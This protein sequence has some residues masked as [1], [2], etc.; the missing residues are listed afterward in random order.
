VLSNLPATVL[1]ELPI[2]KNSIGMSFKLLPAGEFIMG[3]PA[4]VEGRDS[5]ETHETQHKVTLTKAFYLGIHAV[6]RGQFSAFVNETNY[7]TEAEKDGKGGQGVDSAAKWGSS[8]KPENSWRTFGMAQTD[9]HPVVNVTWNDAIAFCDWLS[10]KEGKRY[11]L[12]TEAEWEYGCRAGI[13]DWSSDLGG[14]GDYAWWEYNSNGQT[15]PVGEKKPN[16]WGLYDMLGNVCEW[17]SDWYGKYLDG[18][19]TDPIG[20]MEGSDRVVRGGSWARRQIG[21]WS[22]RDARDPKPSSY[23]VGFRVALSCSRIPE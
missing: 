14:I 9:S 21:G 7:Q 4:S 15:H 17:C 10:T 20:A 11:R 19:V 1:L 3:R 22:E 12:P 2:H 6:T 16:G 8:R 13:A 5:D 18:A 23:D